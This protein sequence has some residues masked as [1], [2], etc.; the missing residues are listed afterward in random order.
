MKNYVENLKLSHHQ[1]L[2]K[3]SEVMICLSFPI[4]VKNFFQINIK[5]DN[6]YNYMKIPQF[7]VNIIYFL[8]KKFKYVKQLKTYL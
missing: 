4:I 3:N 6:I 8:I 1:I 7:I 2:T 5:I